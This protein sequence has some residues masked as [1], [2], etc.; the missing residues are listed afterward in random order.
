M[1]LIVLIIML[2]S[3][4]IR[5]KKE[6]MYFTSSRSGVGD[7]DLQRFRLPYTRIFERN[8]FDYSLPDL[9]SIE[10]FSTQSTFLFNFRGNFR[11]NLR[12]V[13][14]ES[15]NPSHVGRFL[16]DKDV[17]VSTY[18]FFQWRSGM[19][20]D[21]VPLDITVA[22][23]KCKRRETN[24]AI[25]MIF[26]RDVLLKSLDFIRK[27]E[28]TLGTCSV[29]DTGE[30]I[31][32]S[33]TV[34]VLLKEHDAFFFEVD[35]RLKDFKEEHEIDKLWF[36]G[37]R[38][39]MRLPGTNMPEFVDSWIH[40]VKQFD[41]LQ[42]H[43]ATEM[44]Y[45]GPDFDINTKKDIKEGRKE[46]V[47]KNCILACEFD[48]FDQIGKIEH[49]PVFGIEK[50]GYIHGA[51]PSLASDAVGCRNR[52]QTFP[53]LY[54]AASDIKTYNTDYKVYPKE[55]STAWASCISGCFR[56]KPRKSNVAV[57][58]EEATSSITTATATVTA[59]ATAST[60]SIA[61]KI[62]DVI[63]LTLDDDD[64]NDNDN[65]NNL[66]EAGTSTSTSSKKRYQKPDYNLLMSKFEKERMKTELLKPARP[67]PGIY[68]KK[69]ETM[70]EIS[71]DAYLNV[72]YGLHE[73]LVINAGRDLDWRGKIRNYSDVV[74]TRSKLRVE[75][76][77]SLKSYGELYEFLNMKIDCPQMNWFTNSI[78]NFFFNKSAFYPPPGLVLIGKFDSVV[79][80]VW[81]LYV[82]IRL[83][84]HIN[85]NI[86]AINAARETPLPSR[87]KYTSKCC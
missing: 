73:S 53:H 9:D 33:E 3:F 35:S 37:S 13:Y 70:A 1:F 24:P 48:A 43:I 57:T 10:V 54:K 87:M 72:N 49:Y 39:G 14:W 52:H 26:Q 81:P 17:P 27:Y 25:P 51:I 36:G 78:K 86:N 45:L 68:N 64:D 75:V 44:S 41:L 30:V 11:I 19:S 31:R 83:L 46:M 61:S 20:Q 29:A 23:D 6:K 55:G 2:L 60:S 18:T 85:F 32:N 15:Y 42:L 71:Q 7:D 21:G 77:F 74:K 4:F 62:F 22:F 56:Y 59:T 79:N 47:G 5:A 80:S 50:F 82:E 28:N 63:D 67:V 58:V 84:Q 16:F 34:Y 76:I 40:P 12:K 66:P 38:H 8:S 65:D 69:A